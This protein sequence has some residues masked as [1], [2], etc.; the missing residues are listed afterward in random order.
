M[1]LV[2][3]CMMK[4]EAY[5]IIVSLRFITLILCLFDLETTTI[6]F[7]VDHSVTDYVIMYFAAFCGDLTL[8]CQ[9]SSPKPVTSAFKTDRPGNKR[10]RRTVPLLLSRMMITDR[11]TTVMT[12]KDRTGP[13][14]ES[15][16]RC[17]SNV[18]GNENGE[19]T[20][21]HE[22]RSVCDR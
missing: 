17:T 9:H 8:I 21:L 16:D 15:C 5:Y 4:C 3:L 18:M 22:R 10:L 11:P 6:H 20:L 2:A 1:I 7:N 13:A 12:G 19:S 14:D